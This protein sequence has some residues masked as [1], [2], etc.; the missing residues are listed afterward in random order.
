MNSIHSL[1]HWYNWHPPQMKHPVDLQ[2]NDYGGGNQSRKSD[3]TYEILKSYILNAPLTCSD[4]AKYQYV[5]HICY[6]AGIDIARKNSGY[7]ICRIPLKNIVHYL[8]LSQ[9]KVI[10]KS[11]GVFLSYQSAISVVVAA[12]DHHQCSQH[13]YDHVFV[14]KPLALTRKTELNQHISKSSSHHKSKHRSGEKI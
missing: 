5:S 1:S 14:F 13:C 8:S 10:A 3:L 12:L 6:N 11:H 7:L 4:D 9:A 2:H